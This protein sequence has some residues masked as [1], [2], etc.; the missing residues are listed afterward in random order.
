[1]AVRGGWRPLSGLTAILLAYKICTLQR[2]SEISNI[3]AVATMPATTSH[4][5]RSKKL[6]NLNI[7]CLLTFFYKFTFVCMFPVHTPK[8]I[9]H[10]FILDLALF[11]FSGNEHPLFNIHEWRSLSGFSSCASSMKMLFQFQWLCLHLTIINNSCR[12]SIYKKQL[13]NLWLL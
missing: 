10:P 6:V 5:L 11:T 7:N 4:T 1:M 8:T 12:I 3:V 2:K 9:M 13:Q